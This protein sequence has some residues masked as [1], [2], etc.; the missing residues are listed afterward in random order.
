[1]HPTRNVFIHALKMLFK[2]VKCL[3]LFFYSYG[4]NNNY[5]VS[6]CMFYIVIELHCGSFYIIVCC[7][8]GVDG[9]KWAGFHQWGLVKGPGLN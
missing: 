9:I 4:K 7:C 2:K 5:K 1:M 3:F 6:K 8:Y